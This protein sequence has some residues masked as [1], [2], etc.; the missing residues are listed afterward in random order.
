[1]APRPPGTFTAGLCPP[2]RRSGDCSAHWLGLV[3]ALVCCAQVKHYNSS[4]DFFVDLDCSAHNLKI[5]GDVRLQFYNSTEDGK[6]KKL[7]HV[8]LSTAF[9]EKNY[10]CFEKGVIDKVNKDKHHKKVD[11]NFKIE[12]F[13]VNVPDEE[14]EGTAVDADADGEANSEVE[15][16]EEDEDD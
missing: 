2:L 14:I 16:L 10:M 7:F 1:M 9:I 8:W 3:C 6:A 4:T 11:A 12:L 15:E 5:R 13:V